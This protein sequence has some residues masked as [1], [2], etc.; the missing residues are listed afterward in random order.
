MRRFGGAALALACCWLVA[1]HAQEREQGRQ[2]QRDE[3]PA[4]DLDFLEYLGAWAEGDD[5]WLAVETWRK[6]TAADADKAKDAKDP[7]DDEESEDERDDD[8]SK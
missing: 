6:E 7:K 3:A 5:E 1:A 4:P 2:Q 8:E